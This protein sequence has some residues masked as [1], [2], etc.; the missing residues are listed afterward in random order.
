MTVIAS[1]RGLAGSARGGLCA[2]AGNPTK[3]RRKIETGRS[4]FNG[5]AKISFGLKPILDAL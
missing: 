2:K 4:L 3:R 1:V 5:R